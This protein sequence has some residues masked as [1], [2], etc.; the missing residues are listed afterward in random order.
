[1]P[2]NKLASVATDGASAMAGE[3]V[4]L[5]GLTKCDPNFPEFFPIYCIIHREHLTAKHC[6]YEDVIKAVLEIVNFIRVNGINRRQFRN[7]VEELELED[8]PSD[9][10]LYFHYKIAVNKLC[11]E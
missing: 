8:A 1:M 9:V 6:R 4:A 2:L 11:T 3:R 10:S 7:F 5:I